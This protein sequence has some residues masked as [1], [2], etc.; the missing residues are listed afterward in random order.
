M[1]LECEGFEAILKLEAL[2]QHFRI[3]LFCFAFLIAISFL[4]CFIVCL[5]DNQ[6]SGIQTAS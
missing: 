5:H 6:E 2:L 3:L 1:D 4:S